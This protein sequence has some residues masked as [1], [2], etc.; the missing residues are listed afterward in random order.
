MTVSHSE[1]ARALGI[2]ERSVSV[3]ARHCGVAPTHYE[4]QQGKLV[5]FWADDAAATIRDRSVITRVAARLG[6]GADGLA[7]A[8]LAE[9][10]NG[11]L[12][13]S[14]VYR[15]LASPTRYEPAAGGPA[16]EPAAGSR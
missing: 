6:V 8:I 16:T 1:L 9:V 3:T 4:R 15:D 5:P 11:S 7:K 2:P 10:P 14:R 13:V 12:V